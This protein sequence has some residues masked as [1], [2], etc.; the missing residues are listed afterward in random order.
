[1]TDLD[2]AAGIEAADASSM[3]ATLERM[4]RAGL[5]ETCTF[6]VFAQIFEQLTGRPW[7]KARK[8]PTRPK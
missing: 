2:P 1:M 5:S 8:E 7:P 3:A 6:G 4:E